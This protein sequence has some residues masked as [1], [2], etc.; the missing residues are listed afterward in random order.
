MVSK[1]KSMKTIKTPAYAVKLG[2]GM[3]AAN[4]PTSNDWVCKYCMEHPHSG[5]SG[6]KGFI[7]A[8]GRCNKSPTGYHVWERL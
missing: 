2:T 6:A 3:F 7:P 4:L 5:S 1:M 8:S